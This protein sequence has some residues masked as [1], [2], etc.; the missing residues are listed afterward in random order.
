MKI[1]KAKEHKLCCVLNEY[2]SCESCEVAVC[3]PCI[4]TYWTYHSPI[5]NSQAKN[6]FKRYTC[7]ITKQIVNRH[8]SCGPTGPLKLTL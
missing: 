5:L 3:I 1:E 8:S 7:P 6:V 4:S 2:L